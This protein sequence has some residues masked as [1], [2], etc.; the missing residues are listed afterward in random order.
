MRHQLKVI[1]SQQLFYNMKEK[2]IIKMNIDNKC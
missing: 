2:R 1:T